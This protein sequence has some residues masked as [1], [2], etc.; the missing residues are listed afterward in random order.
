ME[1]HHINP[2]DDY[3]PFA[4]DPREAYPEDAGRCNGCGLPLDN[5]DCSN[6]AADKADFYADEVPSVRDQD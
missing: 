4:L 3:N 5:C 1:Q 2:P 6:G